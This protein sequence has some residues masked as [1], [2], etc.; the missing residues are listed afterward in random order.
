MEVQ[1]FNVRSI[2]A[3]LL[4]GVLAT[5]F[6][7]HPVL[8]MSMLPEVRRESVTLRASATDQEAAHRAMGSGFAPIMLVPISS[9]STAILEQQR[10]SIASQ[11]KSL[12]FEAEA[13][14]TMAGE[15]NAED[16]QVLLANPKMMQR[17]GELDSGLEAIFWVALIVGVVVL[18]VVLSDSS[19]VVVNTT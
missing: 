18:L 6:P 13:A 11:L 8:A 1:D 7:A 12:G 17:A 15:L 16:L 4:S 14:A 5:S 2:R 9:V 19:T 3:Q 10:G